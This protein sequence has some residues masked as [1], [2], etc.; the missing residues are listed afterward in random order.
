M[1][2]HCFADSESLCLQRGRPTSA[3]H[4]QCVRCILWRY[5]GSIYCWVA[6]RQS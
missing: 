1:W 4:L 2:S 6:F 3:V 5:I